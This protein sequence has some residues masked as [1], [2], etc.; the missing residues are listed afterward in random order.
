MIEFD[1]VSIKA[2]LINRPSR[3]KLITDLTM[4]LNHIVNTKMS[5]NSFKA[6]INIIIRSMQSLNNSWF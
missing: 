2:I 3:F 6:I 1:E 5:I 4:K